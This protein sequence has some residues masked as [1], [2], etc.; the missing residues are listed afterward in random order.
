MK[1]VKTL[2]ILF[3]G[4][5]VALTACKKDAKTSTEEISQAVKDQIYSIGFGTSNIQKVDDGYL[6]E[7]DIILTPEYLN[8]N[9][10]RLTLRT[11]GEEQYHT[12][13]LVTGL[14]RAISLSLSSKLAAK[15]GYN[16]AL[17]VVRD[18]YN[19]ENLSLTFSIAAPGTGDIN[20]VE[21]HGN[22]LASA[23]FPSSNGTP[24]GTVKVNAQYLGT[25]TSTTFINYLAT[26][27]THE[28]GHCI[29][30]RHTDFYNRSL[31]CGGSAVNEGA[32][33]VGAVWIPGTPSTLDKVDGGSFMLS[34]IS[35]GQNRLFTNYD[36]TALDYLY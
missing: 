1:H 14:P 3:L 15:A 22:Y 11:A 2:A 28:A 31:S 12:T 13:N 34:C 6:V 4:G 24:Y 33:S 20:Y 29:G 5:M 35:S 8:S 9:P 16:Q 19:A 21:G 36:K 25:G 27:M 7:G 30:F 26:I 17:A 23:G 18:R 32:S 10:A